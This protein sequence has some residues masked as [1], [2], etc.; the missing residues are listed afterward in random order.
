MVYLASL[1]PSQW[2]KN[3]HQF[4]TTSPNTNGIYCVTKIMPKHMF[5]QMAETK[6]QPG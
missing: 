1:N 2:R 3:N 5:I 4:E 6:A